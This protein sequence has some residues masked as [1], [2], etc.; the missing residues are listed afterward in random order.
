M[1]WTKVVSAILLLFLLVSLLYILYPI[2]SPLMAHPPRRGWLTIIVSTML[3]SKQNPLAGPFPYVLL[4]LIACLW[5]TATIE[6]RTRKRSTHG[7]AHLA[8]RREARAFVHMTRRRVLLDKARRAI[9]VQRHPP[10]SSLLLGR[11]KGSEISLD[12]K[13]QES[14]AILTAPINAGKSSR[15]VI[16]NLYREQ[17]NRSLFVSDVKGELVRKTAGAVSVYHE[18][19][20]FAPMRPQESEGYNPLAHIRNVEDAQEFARS[21]V[22]NTGKSKEDFWPDAARRLMTATLLHLRV[23][24]PDAPFSRVADILCVM[25]YDQM[26]HTLLTSPSD[27]TREEVTALFDYLDKNPKLVGSLMADTGNRFQLL[28]SDQIRAVTAR[29]DIDFRAMAERPIALYLSIP[30]RYAERYQPLLACFMMQM[31]ATWEEQAEEFPGGHLPRRIMCYLD[32][33]ANLGYIP[34]F[35]TY[36]STARHTGVG[37]LIVLQSFSQIVQKYGRNVLDNIL[38]NTLTHLLLSGAGKEETEYYSARIGNTTVP[39]ETHNTRGYGIEAQDSWTQG[40]T[41]RRLITPDELRTMR[42]DNMLMLASS[43]PPM[44]LKTKLY[45]QDQRLAQLANLPFQPVRI[46]QEPPD[47]PQSSPPL[48]PPTP[49]QQQQLM[50]VKSDKSKDQGNEQYFLQE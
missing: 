12:E 25:T 5:L 18:V 21:W 50:A 44:L 13:Q 33:F 17:G 8:S 20:V 11:Y 30:P 9:Q 36:I 40:E 4:G 28:V 14:N 42:A 2:V 37:M 38:V 27:K 23:A 1:K 48:A 22:D 46:S 10:E 35:S 3:T 26:K 24:E 43:S 15:V 32:E 49:P 31:F 39:T 7:S 45:F 6:M 19:W 41:G 29:N 47:P 34:N 16:P